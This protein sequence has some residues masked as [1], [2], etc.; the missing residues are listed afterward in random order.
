MFNKLWGK[1]G[2]LF[3][4]SKAVG[5]IHFFILP[6]LFYGVG[7]LFFPTKE[8]VVK[9]SLH[10]TMVSLGD[11]WL[12]MVWGG[13]LVL[14]FLGTLN[15]MLTKRFYIAH[16][17]AFIGFM[18]WLF[19]TLMYLQ[20]QNYMLMGAVTLPSMLFWLWLY[21]RIKAGQTSLH[22]LD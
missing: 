11:K 7:F 4:G 16:I 6:T 20:S 14:V 19:A 17:S 22:V 9:S 21:L 2:R 15:T 8:P 12:P 1:V 18:A 10:I 13:V 5:P 3:D